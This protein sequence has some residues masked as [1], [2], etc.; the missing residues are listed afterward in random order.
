MSIDY[1]P[2]KPQRLHS[3]LLEGPRIY[4]KTSNVTQDKN[5]KGK[6]TYWNPNEETK[7]N[8]NT[9]ETLDKTLFTNTKPLPKTVSDDH[10][11]NLG[12]INSLE[13]I[14]KVANI[15]ILSTGGIL[16]ILEFINVTRI[17]MSGS[18][19]FGNS[20]IAFVIAFVGIIIGSVIC[21]SFLHLIKAT[22]FTYLHS[23][24]Q[25]SKIDKII[26]FLSAGSHG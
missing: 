25:D 18:Y 24:S 26:T 12:L 2:N 15:L 20:L 14:L 10:S 9:D 1:L 22:R 11:I 3:P 21:L 5:T 7:I 8:E 4:D 19:E 16:A 23:E 6:R 17:I 13:V